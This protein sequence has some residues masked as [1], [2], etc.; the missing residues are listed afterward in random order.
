MD[1]HEEVMEAIIATL[2]DP[3]G[4]GSDLEKVDDWGMYPPFVDVSGSLDVHHLATEMIR[5]IEDD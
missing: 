3:L 1:K 4:A 5:V 2:K